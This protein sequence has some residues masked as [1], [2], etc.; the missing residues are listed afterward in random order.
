M[1]KISHLIPRVLGK[2]GLKGE[3]SASYITYI[4]TNWIERTLPTFKH[5]LEVTK[6]QD[7]R[8]VIESSHPIASQE[9]SL[10]I[11]E[12]KSNINAHEGININEIMI[13][14]SKSS[15]N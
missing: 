8:L 6:L 12:L 9:L 7:G 3:A 4:A 11:E 15:A 1:D 2:R 13:T 5:N 14:R 10:K